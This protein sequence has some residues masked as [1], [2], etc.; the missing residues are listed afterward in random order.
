M[1]YASVV[2][3]TQYE[4]FKTAQASQDAINRKMM[5]AKNAKIEEGLSCTICI[6]GFDD[7]DDVIRLDCFNNHIFHFDCLK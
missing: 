7:E 4:R 3:K 1:C 2:F 6:D 5:K